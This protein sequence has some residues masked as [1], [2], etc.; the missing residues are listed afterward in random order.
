MTTILFNFYMF[1]FFWLPPTWNTFI[2]LLI[3]IFWVFHSLPSS[4]FDVFLLITSITSILVIFYNSYLDQILDFLFILFS[5]LAILKYIFFGHLILL[6]T[7]FHLNF[8]KKVDLSPECWAG[9][10][11]TATRNPNKGGWS[12]F[13]M[14]NSKSSS[15]WELASA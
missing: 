2:L 11:A 14:A 15:H 9:M 5:C 12:L 1:L 8:T 3:L 7:N 4:L 13:Q 6:E 10:C